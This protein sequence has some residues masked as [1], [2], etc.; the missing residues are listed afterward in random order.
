MDAGPGR[1]ILALCSLAVAAS[2]AFGCDEPAASL[3]PP[4]HA[5]PAEPEVV[6]PE[7]PRAPSPEESARIDALQE[8]LRSCAVT[9]AHFHQRKLYTWTRAEQIEEL[10]RAPT[11]L[12]RSVGATGQPSG[13]DVSLEGDD[14]ALAVWL[15]SPRRTARRF[16]WSVPWA[17][18]MG[19]EEGDYGDR[20]IAVTLR[21]GSWVARFAP[22]EEPRWRVVDADGLEVPLATAER[23]PERI[24]VVF[25][26]GRGS[27]PE[28]R[29]RVYREI[30][31]VNEAQ[32][33]RWS[34][35]T[36]EI[37]ARLAHDAEQLRA[38]AEIWRSFPADR[39]VDVDGL[40]EWL[41]ARWHTSDP[42]LS[43]ADAY[44]RCL[45]LGS[46][47]VRPEPDALD[48][49]AAAITDLPAE[50]P[51]EHEVLTRR[52]P[53]GRASAAGASRT[54]CDPTGGCWS[55]SPGGR[56]VRVPAPPPPAQ[57]PPR[58]TRPVVD[59]W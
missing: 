13:F 39:P 37:T 16:A 33:D 38:L 9:D 56:A 6:A 41:R 28:G 36:E 17:T 11:L 24:A 26:L 43:L 34:V 50:A 35:G 30:V 25:H 14:S 49:I 8:W 59:V 52:A 19:W 57:S 23:S 48:A 10:R 42:D 1:W 40:R 27:D 32:V 44:A 12:T 21:D 47:E 15:R 5:A 31:I 2:G 22:D 29:E 54:I 18:R 7:A 51:L 53:Y 3:P 20:L 55:V 45:A 46:T 4:T 58:Q